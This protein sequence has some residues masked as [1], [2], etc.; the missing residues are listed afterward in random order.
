MRLKIPPAVIV[1]VSAVVMWLVSVATPKL[2]F[3]F[4]GHFLAA[5]FIFFVGVEGAYF[6]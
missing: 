3:L 5:E 2:T 4:P 1:S 6:W